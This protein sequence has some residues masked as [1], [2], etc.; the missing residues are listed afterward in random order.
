MGQPIRIC[1]EKIS[2]NHG[3]DSLE[4]REGGGGGG[5]GAHGLLQDVQWH[6]SVLPD[7]GKEVGGPHAVANQQDAAVRACAARQTRSLG[8]SYNGPVNFTWDAKAEG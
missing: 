8:S 6:V 1:A 7:I 2:L 4:S 5:H 3:V